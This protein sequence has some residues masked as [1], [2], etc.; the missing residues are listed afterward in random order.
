[1]EQSSNDDVLSENLVYILAV[2]AVIIPLQTNQMDEEAK[3]E[4][5]VLPF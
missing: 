3:Q 4:V 5:K 1:M 2:L